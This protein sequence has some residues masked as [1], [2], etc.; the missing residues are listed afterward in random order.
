MKTNRI[1]LL[2]V[3]LVMLQTAVFGQI[4]GANMGNPVNIGTLLPG[5]S[6]SDTKNNSPSNG[7]RNDYGQPS[8]DIYYKFVLSTAGEV[9]I[10]TCGSNFDTYVHLLNSAGTSIISNDDN[11][12]LCAG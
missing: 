9:S 3:F 11:G 12:P 5:Q 6:F 2:S 10:S 4:V 7:Y 1:F 8:D